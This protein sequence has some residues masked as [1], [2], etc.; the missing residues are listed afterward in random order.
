M[1]GVTVG[2]DGYAVGARHGAEPHRCPHLD[3]HSLHR[4]SVRASTPRAHPK[5]PARLAIDSESGTDM[6]DFETAWNQWHAER[7]SYGDPPGSLHPPNTDAVQAAIGA[8]A[9]GPTT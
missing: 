1:T 5:S 4:V 3:D 6:S 7:E 8:A 9:V 2:F